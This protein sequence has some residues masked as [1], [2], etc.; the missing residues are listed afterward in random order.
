LTFLVWPH[1]HPALASIKFPSIPNPHVEAYID[2]G[3]QWPDAR[4]GGY[5][6]GGKPPPAFPTGGSLGPCLNYGASLS[7][8]TV[9]GGVTY[10]NQT[11]VQCSFPSAGVI[12]IID[13][14]GKRQVMLVHAGKTVL[15]RADASPTAASVTVPAKL[16]KKASA[17]GN[18]P[19]G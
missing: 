8:G 6:I 9:T 5:I 16:C 17:P 10:A 19:T 15:A 7:S 13:L 2:F 4:A 11:A 3:N 1:G 14:P 12:D 18:P